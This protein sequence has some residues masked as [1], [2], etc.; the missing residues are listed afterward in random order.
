MTRTGSRRPSL[1]A[2]LAGAALAAAMP[3]LAGAAVDVSL[4]EW[5]VGI[6]PGGADAGKVTFAVRNEGSYPHAF[7][8]ERDGSEVARTDTLSPG[9]STTVTVDLRKGRYELYCP[10]E[11]HASSGM[12]TMVE[13][14]A[15]G[16]RVVEG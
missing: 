10:I 7:E 15:D 8:V 5:K 3:G 11:G 13:V 1:R 2:G 9:E 14:S 6:E 4:S 16:L 12:E